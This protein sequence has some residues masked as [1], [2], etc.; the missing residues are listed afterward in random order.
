MK[1][2]TATTGAQRLAIVMALLFSANE[3][4]QLKLVHISYFPFR[5]SN[6]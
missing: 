4:Q 2:L 6:I 1:V 5:E 3:P